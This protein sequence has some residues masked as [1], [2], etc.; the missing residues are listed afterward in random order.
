MNNNKIIIAGLIIFAVAFFAYG[1]SKPDGPVVKTYNEEMLSFIA[2]SQNGRELF[3]VNVYPTTLFRLNNL[4]VQYQFD[5]IVRVYSDA[6]ITGPK[7]VYGFNSTY[8]AVIEIQDR[9]F[10][11]INKIIG[12]QSSLYYPLEIR[13]NRYAYFVKIYNDSYEYRGWR[14][15]G[16]SVDN[17]TIVNYGSFSGSNK[18][19]SAFFEE[20]RPTIG[21]GYYFILRNNIESIPKG[22]NLN[23]D[24]FGDF[25]VF[26]ETSDGIRRTVTSQWQTPSTTSIFYRQIT[27]VGQ[28]DYLLDTI[29]TNPFV[30]DTALLQKSDVIIPY[31]VGF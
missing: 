5:S 29:A 28:F 11:K 30:V 18:T 12:A 7:N 17:E 24:K 13:L 9:Y 6:F 20:F 22:S 23:Y 16:Y 3:P 15:W 21:L 8:D 10:G 27:V 4:D 26:A 2:D 31:K 1:C 19:I 14:F 25:V